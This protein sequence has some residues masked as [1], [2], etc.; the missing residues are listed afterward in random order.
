MED[1][2]IKVRG[3]EDLYAADLEVPGDLSSAS[4]FIVAAI[5]S[6]SGGVRVNSV[7][8]NPTRDGV[9]TILRGMGAQIKIENVGF[10]PFCVCFSMISDFTRKIPF[11]NY[12]LFTFAFL[13]DYILSKFVSYDLKDIY[14][15]AVFFNVKKK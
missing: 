8:L 6:R 9:I 10:G 4:F 13:L 5:L 11:L 2:E 12:F 1:G 7:G 3:G 14:P 15:I